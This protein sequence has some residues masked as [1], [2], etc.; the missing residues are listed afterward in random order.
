MRKF[1]M[2]GAILSSVF[3]ILGTLKKSKDEPRTW[4]AILLWVGWAVGAGLAIGSV[5][6]KRDEE[7]QK[8]AE[9]DIKR[10]RK[11]AK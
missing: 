5:L 10:A 2:N 6:D 8:T 3:G 11:N 4:R 9:R 1:L 7:R